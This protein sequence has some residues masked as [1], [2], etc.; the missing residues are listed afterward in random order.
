MTRDPGPT[1]ARVELFWIPLGAGARVPVVRTSGRIFEA[2]SAWR[3]HRSRENLYHAALVVHVDGEQWT[4]E[5]A[6]V[7]SS[8]DPE[9]G[10]VVT[11]PVGSALLGR[12]R[13][14]Q[15]EV[16]RWRS[17]SIPDLTYAVGDA[18]VALEDDV[19]VR[20][21]LDLVPDVPVLT[22]GRDTD[23]L[24]EM[25]NSNSVVAWLLERCD[26]DTGRIPLPRRG[27]APGWD[28]GARLAREAP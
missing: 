15:Y 9:R 22:W 13:W 10:A 2:L 25:W 6:P 28:A 24:G 5:M 3:Q 23:H 21:L 12:S 1:A 19:A 20:R 16:R 27:R 17:G 4:I 14:F 26:V 11:G 18:V 7:W 8:K